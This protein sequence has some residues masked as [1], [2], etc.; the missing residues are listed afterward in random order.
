[1]VCFARGGM[2]MAEFFAELKRRQIF[3][4]AAAYAVVPFSTAWHAE[5]AWVA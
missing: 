4:V 2:G 1:M 3:R 5:Q